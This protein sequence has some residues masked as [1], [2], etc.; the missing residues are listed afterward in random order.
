MIN[1]ISI[2]LS[3]ISIILSIIIILKNRESFLFTPRELCG[4]LEGNEFNNC[5]KKMKCVQNIDCN[6]QGQPANRGIASSHVDIGT[7][8]DCSIIGN[9]D[10]I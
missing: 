9:C 4:N 1:F 6:L 8:G 7:F 10:T 2:I 3:T 5:I